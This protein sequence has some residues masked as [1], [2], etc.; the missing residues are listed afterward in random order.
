[1][2]QVSLT[3]FELVDR[4]FRC[5]S[6]YGYSNWSVTLD[7]DLNGAGKTSFETK[8]VY[9]HPDANWEVAI[10]EIAHVRLGQFRTDFHDKEWENLVKNMGGTPRTH[11][12]KP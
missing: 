3:P 10:H 11:Y 12:R 4:T 2:Q 9:L 1:M 8:T 5:L 6:T 7:P